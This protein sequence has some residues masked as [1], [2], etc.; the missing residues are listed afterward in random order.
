MKLQL[1][2]GHNFIAIYWF[3]WNL[4]AI[5]ILFTVV[6]FIFR[7]HSVF[8]LQIILILCHSSQYSGYYNKIINKYP[9]RQART[10]GSFFEDTPFAVTGF[11]LAHYKII[12]NLQKHKIKT[13]ILSWLIYNFFDNYEIFVKTKGAFYPGFKRNIRAIC[14]IFIYSLF[15]SDKIT[16]KYIAKFLQM[17]TNYT[18]VVYYLHIP[19]RD[20]LKYYINDIKNLNFR[21]LIIDYFACFSVGFFGTLIFGK[22]PL[23]YLFC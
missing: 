12:D 15:P 19:L 8:I 21:G 7:K 22:T 9:L 13:L 6:I 1:L 14:I 5:T 18:G 23:K 3:L 17:I 10:I 4:I 11:I 16:N 2:W 20:Y